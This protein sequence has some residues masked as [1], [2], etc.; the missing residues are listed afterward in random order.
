MATDIRKNAA[1]MPAAEFENFLKAC[2]LLKSTTAP[3]ATVS[4]YDQWVSIHGSIMG[5]K[6][7][8]STALVNLGH[9]NIGFLPWHREYVLRR[10]LV[11]FE[12]DDAVNPNGPAGGCR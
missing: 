3:G 10:C 12:Y 4:I 7:P 5:V 9:Q 11:G 8:G 2:V 1:T 6:T